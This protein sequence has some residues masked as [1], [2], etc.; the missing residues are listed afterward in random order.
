MCI[1]EFRRA[2]KG[3]ADFRQRLY[4]EHFRQVR[5]VLPP[6]EEQRAIAQRI[7]LETA[8]IDRVIVPIEA[9]ID[10]LRELRASLITAAVTGQIDVATW[11]KHGET[12]PRL[13]RIEEKMR[14]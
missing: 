5:V 12:G 9:S 7:Q 11:G 6:I 10:R 14:A 1:E 3:I 13:D 4:W 2:S 8:A